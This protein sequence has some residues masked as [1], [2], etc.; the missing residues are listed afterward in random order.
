[1]D[2]N[3]YKTNFSPENIA[4]VVYQ[5]N[6]SV[7]STIPYNSRGKMKLSKK[8][9]YYSSTGSHLEKN[10]ISQTESI[11]RMDGSFY[12]PAGGNTKFV[13]KMSTTAGIAK[14][15]LLYLNCS[16]C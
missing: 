15:N 6:S 13:R 16:P 14:S 8:H 2:E 12:K 3:K 9:G 5:G 11:V 10:P 4:K 7:L 1:M